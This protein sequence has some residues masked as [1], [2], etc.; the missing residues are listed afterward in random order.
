MNLR[1]AIITGSTKYVESPLNF[2]EKDM[3]L[4]ENT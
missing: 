1:K 4:I 3:K 2:P